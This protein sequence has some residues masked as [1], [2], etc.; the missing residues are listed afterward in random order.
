M[1]Y[2]L[3]EKYYNMILCNFTLFF[4]SLS[5]SLDTTERKGEV[6]SSNNEMKGLVRTKN[7]RDDDDDDGGGRRRKK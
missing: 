5:L 2:S 6:G 1:V 4:R 7:R 3:L